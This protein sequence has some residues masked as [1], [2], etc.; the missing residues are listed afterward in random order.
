MAATG[1]LGYWPAGG[2]A[3]AVFVVYQTLGVL[4]DESGLIL[5]EVD[6]GDVDLSFTAHLLAFYITHAFY[7]FWLAGKVQIMR[8]TL[9]DS[10]PEA[11]KM[12]D[13]ICLCFCG[14]CEIIKHG[15]LID[16]ATGVKTECPCKLVTT[17][18]A[19]VG[20]PVQV[21]SA[22]LVQATVIQGQPVHQMP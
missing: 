11:K 3:L 22:P 9:G 5:G 1:T 14:C 13:C 6:T 8:K 21:Q 18:A 20:T 16:A 12:S 7:A 19:P 15:R 17:Y 10:K 2:S 4:I